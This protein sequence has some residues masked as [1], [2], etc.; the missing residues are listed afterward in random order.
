MFHLYRGIFMGQQLVVFYFQRQ[1]GGN[2]AN[3]SFSTLYS[4]PSTFKKTKGG[5]CR[6]RDAE[7]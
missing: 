3:R 6:F 1:A 4:T 2:G 7:Q 5:A